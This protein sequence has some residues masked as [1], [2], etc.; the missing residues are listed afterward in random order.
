MDKSQVGLVTVTSLNSLWRKARILVF[1][2]ARVLECWGGS[3]GVGMGLV[4]EGIFG[5]VRSVRCAWIYFEE[6]GKHNRLEDW[7]SLRVPCY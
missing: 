2:K 6:S 7:P 3:V 5:P 4:G 1:K